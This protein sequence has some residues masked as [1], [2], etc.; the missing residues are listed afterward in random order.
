MPDS[1]KLY[2]IPTDA[3]GKWIT[4]DDGEEVLIENM[5]AVGSSDEG[6]YTVV[7]ARQRDGTSCTFRAAWPADEGTA[8]S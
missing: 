3:L 4:L 6:L 7:D 5:G 1:S 8:S 2:R